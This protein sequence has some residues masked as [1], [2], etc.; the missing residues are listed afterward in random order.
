M[1][2]FLNDHIFTS[3][4]TSAEVENLNNISILDDCY[5]LKQDDPNGLQKSN[6]QGWHSK[7]HVLGE[8]EPESENLINL[9]KQVLE[10][11]Q[12]V[13]AMQRINL[14]IS[15]VAWWI[16]INPEHSYNVLHSHP[17]ADLSVVYYAKINN[18]NG[19]LVL[20]RNDGACHTSLYKHQPNSI[21]IAIQPNV[22]RLY[23]FPSYLLHYVENNL[24][25]DDRVSIAFN[26]TI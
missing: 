15:K 9:S 21:K 11:G 12:Q 4:L 5:R 20:M 14:K 26:L 23:A 19:S 10:F 22:G 7:V 25:Q 16:N 17:K 24:S 6:A 3:F 13:L 2:N 8:T 1:K 18:E